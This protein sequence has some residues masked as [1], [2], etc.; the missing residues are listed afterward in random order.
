[1]FSWCCTYLSY[2]LP[3]KGDLVVHMIMYLSLWL[4]CTSIC[5]SVNLCIF[6][7]VDVF[8]RPLLSFKRQQPRQ[9]AKLKISDWLQLFVG[10]VMAS[11]LSQVNKD[12]VE[13]LHSGYVHLNFTY[14][15]HHAAVTTLWK[16]FN[17]KTCEMC[18]LRLSG[19]ESYVCCYEYVPYSREG[20]IIFF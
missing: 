3:K 7:D 19:I 1:M 6:C 8:K 20:T 15:T 5:V 17:D 2:Y 14:L 9:K 10:N 11:V 16:Q 12:P 4:W 13:V 18:C